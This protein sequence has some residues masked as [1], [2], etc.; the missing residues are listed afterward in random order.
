M[1]DCKSWDWGWAG[2]GGEPCYLGAASVGMRESQ[3]GCRPAKL[4]HGASWHVLR[5]RVSHVRLDHG[6]PSQVQ[7][8]ALRGT[9][10]RGTLDI[11]LLGYTHHW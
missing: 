8:S 5:L 1:G 4:G 9:C 11:L 6:T 3:N 2:L 10:G 7:D